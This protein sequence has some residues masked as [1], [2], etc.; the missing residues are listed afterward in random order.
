[1]CELYELGLLFADEGILF[2]LEHCLIILTFKVRTTAFYK[3]LVFEVAIKQR[4]LTGQSVYLKIQ[5][6]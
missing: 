1:M 6:S 2:N 4:H 5:S 3:S